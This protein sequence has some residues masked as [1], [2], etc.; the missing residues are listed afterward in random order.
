MC[1]QR[2]VPFQCLPLQAHIVHLPDPIHHS[3]RNEWEVDHGLHDGC[4]FLI[5]PFELM[6]MSDEGLPLQ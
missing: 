1:P 3:C 6:F 2:S 5:H 4:S